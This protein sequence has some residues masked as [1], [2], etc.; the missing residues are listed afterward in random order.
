MHPLIA[1]HR[2]TA[3][4]NCS[5]CALHSLIIIIIIIVII[6]TIIGYSIALGVKGSS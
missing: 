5:L 1:L 6:T 4:I 3:G 2:F